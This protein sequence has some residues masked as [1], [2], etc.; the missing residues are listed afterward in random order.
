[1]CFA[2][3]AYTEGIGNGTISHEV[4]RAGFE[5]LERMFESH[6]ANAGKDPR[7][8]YLETEDKS[9]GQRLFVLKKIHPTR[10]FDLAMAAVLSNQARLDALSKGLKPQRQKS[11]IFGR[12]Y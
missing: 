10:K 5:R 4:G 7:E 3:H 11:T 1:M 6:V 12:I 2:V 9:Q 8:V